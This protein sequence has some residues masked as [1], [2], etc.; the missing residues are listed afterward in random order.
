MLDWQ[1]NPFIPGGDAQYQIARTPEFTIYRFYEVLKGKEHWLARSRVSHFTDNPGFTPHPDIILVTKGLWR[2]TAPGLPDGS[3]VL[4]ANDG[5]FQVRPAGGHRVTAESENGNGYVCITPNRHDWY[6]RELVI[7]PAGES[8]TLPDRG[9]SSF[10]YIGKGLAEV[11][12]EEADP[13]EIIPLTGGTT[14][15][16]VTKICAV[17]FW[18]GAWPVRQADLGERT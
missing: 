7:I 5:A 4:S 1:V 3:V 13:N 2:F 17:T 10:L 16:A 14:I 18:K 11:N 9:S 12:G 15:K 8:L 6:D